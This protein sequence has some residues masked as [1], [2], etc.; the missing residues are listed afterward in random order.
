ME[1]IYSDEQNRA[2]LF[3]EKQSPPLIV[4]KEIYLNSS[5]VYL[6]PFQI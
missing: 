1:P 6:K 3:S 5:K 4:F 2:K